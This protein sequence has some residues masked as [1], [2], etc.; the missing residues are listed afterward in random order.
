V[1]LPADRDPPLVVG[2]QFERLVGRLE[3]R[4]GAAVELV[5]QAALGGGEQKTLVGEAR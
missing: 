1:S 4:L 3:Q 5:A 2:D